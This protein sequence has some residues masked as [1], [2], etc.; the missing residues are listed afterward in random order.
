MFNQDF[1]RRSFPIFQAQSPQMKTSV[2][3]SCPAAVTP[4]QP[5]FHRHGVPSPQ[6]SVSF[7]LASL[8]LPS[9]GCF[10]ARTT[11]RRIGATRVLL[12]RD[13]VSPTRPQFCPAGRLSGQNNSHLA[14]PEGFLH[15]LR[16]FSRKNG[17]LTRTFHTAR[18]GAPVCNRLWA[19]SEQ[20]PVANRRSVLLAFRG[21][22]EICRLNLNDSAEKA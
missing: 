1:A 20:K 9:N 11:R 7:G 21:A 8:P 4:K 17:T 22:C 10:P 16:V 14:L 19:S 2:V 3:S 12:R 13:A 5:S 6:S 18:H 15:G